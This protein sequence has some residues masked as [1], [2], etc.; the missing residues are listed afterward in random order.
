M[1]F[2]LIAKHERFSTGIIDPNSS[3]EITEALAKASQPN[4][5]PEA[6]CLI[7]IGTIS[8]AAGD[9]SRTTVCRSRRQTKSI[10]LLN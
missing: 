9:C 7:L 2:S 6:E 8:G 5:K 4:A 1:R 10:K 3:R